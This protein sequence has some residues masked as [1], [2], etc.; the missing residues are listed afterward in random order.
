MTRKDTSWDK[1]A[2]W[3]DKHV[4]ETS[5]HQRDIIIP[6][7]IKLIDPKKDEKVIDVGCGQGEFCRELA[8]H[9]AQVVG[10]EVRRSKKPWTS[11]P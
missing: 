7:A 1:V 8:R 9:G 10:I 4:S 3:Y 11:R 5:D 6:G 2:N